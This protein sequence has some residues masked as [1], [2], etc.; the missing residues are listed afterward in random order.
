M[1]MCKL[2]DLKEKVINQKLN[3]QELC[4]ET[5][6]YRYGKILELLSND[7]ECKKC[8]NNQPER[9][10]RED[11]LHY[12]K[13]EL[14]EPNYGKKYHGITYD[15]KDAL[16]WHESFFIRSYETHYK[17]KDMMRCSEHCGNTVSE[18]Q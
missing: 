11:M 12:L 13:F 9:S 10:K 2:C 8:S 18:A 17:N 7:Y 1:N 4:Y 5:I 3:Y 16:E 6:E 15:E 14:S